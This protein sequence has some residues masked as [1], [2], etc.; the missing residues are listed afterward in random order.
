[1]DYGL[2]EEAQVLVREMG[3]ALDASVQ[4]VAVLGDHDFKSGQPDAV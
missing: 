2:P 3:I 1:V 4:V